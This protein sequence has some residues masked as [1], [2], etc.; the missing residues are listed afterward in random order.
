MKMGKS[1]DR[2]STCMHALLLYPTMLGA[3]KGHILIG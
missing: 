3:F 1:R 2:H